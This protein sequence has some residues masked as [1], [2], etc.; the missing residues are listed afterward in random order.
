M[1]YHILAF[2]F[3]FLLDLLLGD[4]YYFP[5]PIRLIGRLIAGLEK[6][7]LKQPHRNEKK[8][9]KNGIVLV[10]TVLV[11]TVM[12]T[13]FFLIGAYY[14]HPYLGVFAETIMT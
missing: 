2:F 1:K 9:L 14:L 10:V 13:A 6:R 11:I 3:G 8:E 7:L 4:P 12:I 5:H